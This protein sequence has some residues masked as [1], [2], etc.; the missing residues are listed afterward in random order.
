MCWEIRRRRS[1]TSTKLSFQITQ[2][3]TKLRKAYAAL[4]EAYYKDHCG[5]MPETYAILAADVAEARE[6][7]ER[8]TCDKQ[9]LKNQKRCTSCGAWMAN[10]DR[11]CGKCGAENEIL[12]NDP[13]PETA[14]EAAKEAATEEIFEE[15]EPKTETVQA[16]DHSTGRSC[17]RGD[18]VSFLSCICKSRIILLSGM[19]TEVIIRIN[20]TSRRKS[21]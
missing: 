4:G 11:F 7:L 19:R 12:K 18:G 17:G 6:R 1:L 14:K 10:E 9:I 20:N 2:E 8:L 13:E 16:R 5:D 15:E 3:E 21:L